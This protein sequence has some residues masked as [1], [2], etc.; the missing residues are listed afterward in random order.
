MGIPDWSE[1]KEKKILIYHTMWE[2]L[3]FFLG[4]R[5][6]LSNEVNVPLFIFFS[7]GFYLIHSQF[8]SFYQKQTL[9]E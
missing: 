5:P 4:Y 3:E 9:I 2:A 1:E 7:W 6:G 8:S